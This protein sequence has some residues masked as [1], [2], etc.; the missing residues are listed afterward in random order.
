MELDYGYRV[1]ELATLLRR[2]CDSS[3]ASSISAAH[4]AK[5]LVL[6]V[7]Q[8]QL[9]DLITSLTHETDNS[10]ASIRI[11]SSASAS[12]GTSLQ[13]PA[14]ASDGLNVEVPSLAVLLASAK[15]SP[16]PALAGVES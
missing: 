9:V 10:K 4:S 13:S 15:H 6:A 7:D 14:S 8:R 1:I 12:F 5:Q 2:P 3:F 11:E 16:S